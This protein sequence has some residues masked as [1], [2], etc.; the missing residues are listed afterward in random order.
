LAISTKFNSNSNFGAYFTFLIC[1]LDIDAA[2]SF[3]PV[4]V[5]LRESLP[6]GL[7]QVLHDRHR[8]VERAAHPSQQH[9]A[10]AETLSFPPGC[11]EPVYA[12]EII[13]PKNKDAQ[14][15]QKRAFSRTA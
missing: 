5:L 11:P 15:K 13:S 6:R 4:A 2:G 12:N 10:P 7:R 9:I 8:H 1:I 3:S 14:G